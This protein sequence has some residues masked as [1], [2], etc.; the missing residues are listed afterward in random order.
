MRGKKISD[1]ELSGIK[2]KFKDKS[3]AANCNREIIKEIEKTGISLEEFFQLSLEA[4]KSI[5]DQIGL[6]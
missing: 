1:M 6:D 3:F 4:I 2:K 5:K